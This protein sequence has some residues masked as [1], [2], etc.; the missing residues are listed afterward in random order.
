MELRHLTGFVAVAEELHF[1]RAATRLHMSQSP[2]SQQIRLLE[3]DLGVRLFDRSTR[4]VSLTAAGEGLLEPARDVLAAAAVARRAATAAGRGE[5]GRVSIGFA[6]TSSSV[7]LPQLTRAVATELPGIELVLQ[8]PFYSAETTTR[9]A[10]GTLDLAFA[11]AAGG[12][13][14]SARVVQHDRLAVALERS[15]RLADRTSISLGEL[16]DDDFVTLPSERGSEVRELGIRSCLD[17]GFVPR[18][19]QEAP[20][21][22]SLLALVGAR[23]GV[24]LV[25]ETVRAVTPDHVVVVPLDEPAPALPLSLVW[26]TTG[27]S[28]ALTAVLEVA[29]R[30]LPTLQA[31]V[32]GGQGR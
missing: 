14:L 8:G 4:S 9:V 27:A 19:A 30:A 28:S 18:V 31:P 2:L 12:R 25:V 23:L 11:V 22:L 26:R 24:A 10:D 3:R 20:D 5:V 6:G 17:A 13:G 1:G 7:G 32:D 15:H 16:A 29:E 21:S